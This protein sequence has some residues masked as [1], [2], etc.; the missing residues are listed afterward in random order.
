MGGHRLVQQ[1][2]DVGAGPWD[3]F[4]RELARYG[5]GLLRAW[6]RRGTIYGKAKALTGYG[7]GRIEGWPDPQTA[8]DLAANTVVTAMEYFRDKVLKTHRW[9]SAYRLGCITRSTHRRREFGDKN[10]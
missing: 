6:I 10:R 4:A 7:L 9:Q 8:D 5:L 2:W 1:C 3:R